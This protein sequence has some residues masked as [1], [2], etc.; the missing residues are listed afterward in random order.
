M[1]DN[2]I[3][4][5]QR[6]E[7]LCRECME[8]A[9][10]EYESQGNHH[11]KKE[12]SFIQQAA[13]YR[14]EMANLSTGE[15][16]N[17]QQRRLNELNRRMKEI[18]Q[19]LKPEGMKRV[20]EREKGPSKRPASIDQGKKAEMTG[21]KDDIDV[22][23]WF[24]EAPAHT[25]GDVCGMAELKEQLKGCAEDC[26]LE[27]IKE[28][29]KLKNLHSY[30]FIGPPG[31]GKTYMIEAFAA[32]LMKQDYKYLSLTGSDILSKYVGDAEKIVTKLFETAEENAPCIIF[33]D[34]IDGICKNRSLPNLPDYAASITTAFLVGYNRIHSANKKIIFIGATNYPNQVDT[35]MLD[36]VELIQV[37]LPDKEAR[38]FY[39]ARSLGDILRLK[40][41]ITPECMAE[42]TEMY[43]YRDI[44]RLVDR[45]KRIVV[46]E[47][48]AEYIHEK[49]A[50]EALKSG[51]F[52]L[53]RELF[54]QA[55]RDCVPSPKESILKELDAWVE[56]FQKNQDN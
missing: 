7:N 50:I 29:M 28:Y 43:N 32:E 1:E 18:V 30:F 19:E 54:E 14:A 34:E 37:P 41:D 5:M 27:K 4:N 25:F 2:Y 22:S 21:G 46:K 56:R 8:N 17:F 33:I 12:A 20:E 53:S 10:M 40:E 26:H 47:V 35:A 39:F 11:S 31:C 48:M 42:L 16:R 49:A 55:Q 44:D 51:S 23:G 24:K 15:E 52:V 9:D 45:I 3:R 38:E 36:R 13:L 6:Y